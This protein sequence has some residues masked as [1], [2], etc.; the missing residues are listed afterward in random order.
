MN[1]NAKEDFEKG[2]AKALSVIVAL[3]IVF[4]VGLYFYIQD[5]KVDKEVLKNKEIA[6]YN[7]K[8]REYNQAKLEEQRLRQ[9]QYNNQATYST[10]DFKIKYELRDRYPNHE[11]LY[12]METVVR[13]L[14]RI[15]SKY[16]D[17][18]YKIEIVGSISKYGTLFYKLYKN[19][20]SSEYDKE[21][22]S[23]LE[24]LKKI[25]YRIR[26][27]DTSFKITIDN[28]NMDLN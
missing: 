14:E 6:E 20:N 10:K 4:V 24:E 21:F 2:S 18:G 23:M 17:N 16:Q 7:Q 1:F 13:N 28:N 5:L 22:Y 3:A 26:N 15:K 9:K 25:K 27:N 19:T 11:D 12:N 8:V